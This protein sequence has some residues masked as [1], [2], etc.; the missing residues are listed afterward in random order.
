MEK[1]I[2]NIED[3]YPLTI[4]KMRYGGKIVIF[5]ADND[6]GFVDS[7]QGDEEV[8]YVINDWLEEHVSPCLYGIGDTIWSAFEDY[9]KRLYEY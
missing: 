3:I 5:N 2:E 9:K 4:V 8:Y 6:S 7:V 1:K